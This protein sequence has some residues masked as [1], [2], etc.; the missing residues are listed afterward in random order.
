MLALSTA[1][2]FLPPPAGQ[3]P[4]SGGAPAVGVDYRI[5]P[6]CAIP[7]QLG[8]TWWQWQMIGAK[9]PPPR[10]EDQGVTPYPVPGVIQLRT[11]DEAVF[12]ADVDR[13]QIPLKRITDLPLTGGCL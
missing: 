10:P 13:S 4:P 8:D 3:P 5:N 6:S 1:C 12:T 9:W 2:G 7:V 11:A